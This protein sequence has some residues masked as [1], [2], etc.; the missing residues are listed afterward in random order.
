[1]SSLLQVEKSLLA[2]ANG[3]TLSGRFIHH[4][5]FP[6]ANEIVVHFDLQDSQGL[7]DSKS[8]SSVLF[9]VARILFR[10]RGA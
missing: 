5:G 8:V 9:I 7:D 1:M 4:H 2:E 10:N 3:I 6:Q